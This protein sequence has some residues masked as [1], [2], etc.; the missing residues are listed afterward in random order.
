MHI[1]TCT[2][3]T[4]EVSLYLIYGKTGPS[5]YLGEDHIPIALTNQATNGE[6]RCPRRVDRSSTYLANGL[7]DMYLT[8]IK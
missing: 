5:E 2:Q 3:A 1:S 8:R 6:R 4:Q 7:K